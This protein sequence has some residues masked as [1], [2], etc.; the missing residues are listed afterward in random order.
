LSIYRNWSIHAAAQIGRV[1]FYLRLIGV[2]AF[3]LTHWRPMLFLLPNAF[4]YYFIFYEVVRS[5]WSPRKLSQREYLW[6]AAVIWILKLPQEY[7]IHIARL[8]FTNVLKGKVLGAPQHTGWMEAIRNSPVSFAVMLAAFGTLIILTRVT[9]RHFAGPPEHALRLVAPPLPEKIDEAPE[10]DREVATS[11][12]LF[13][14][15]LVEKIVLAG[16]VTVIFAQI[17]PGVDT[18][19]P[20]LVLGTGL[21]V[22]IN[23]F[24]GL[25][26]AR[27]N[28]SPE[29]GIGLF[30]VVVLTN[31]TVAGIAEALLRIRGGNGLD[32]AP[33]IFFLILLTLVVTLYDRWRP[34]FD[35][36]FAK[37]RGGRSPEN[38]RRSS[39]TSRR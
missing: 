25:R 37:Q 29:S 31:V 20:K 11:W 18:G 5:R 28:A 21:I 4:E 35:V 16:F 36:R 17:V 39:R 27:R 38:R 3:E 26:R 22:I 8:D 33:T 13:D 14:V 32:M 34:V 12:R 23:A 10:R 19:P 24:L 2:V 6:A 15:H 9:I 30:V 1:L 7:W